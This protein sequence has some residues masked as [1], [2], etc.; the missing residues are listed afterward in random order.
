MYPG[1]NILTA[2]SVA[3]KCGMVSPED[4]IIQVTIPSAEKTK[5]EHG[6]LEYKKVERNITNNNAETDVDEDG[7]QVDCV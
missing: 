4:S 6:E 3:G 2:I 7:C 1:D 5:G